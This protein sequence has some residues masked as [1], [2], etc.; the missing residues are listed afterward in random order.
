MS[1]SI[2]QTQRRH[3]PEDGGTCIYH[4]PVNNDLETL[5]LGVWI[6]VGKY[7][8]VRTRFCVQH[9]YRYVPDYV[10]SINDDT[11][12]IMCEAWIT[13][14]TRLCVKP[15]WRY[16][17]DSVC[18]RHS[19]TSQKTWIFL[20]LM[21]DWT[22]HTRRHMP[23]PSLQAL[24]KVLRNFRPLLFETAAFGTARQHFVWILTLWRRIFFLNFSTLCM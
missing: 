9:K 23:S 4:P 19:V 20:S 18:S 3:F 11:Y 15:V 12:Q 22:R 5:K 6:L 10:C 21:S 16:V 7:I 17:P 13:V 2:Y 24:P 8:T 1:P 14:R